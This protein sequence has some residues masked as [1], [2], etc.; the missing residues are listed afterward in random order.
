MGATAV[1]QL[2]LSDRAV[3][4]QVAAGAGTAVVITLS[5]VAGA[6]ALASAVGVFFGYY[7]CAASPPCHWLRRCV[8]SGASPRR[9]SLALVD[10]EAL[11]TGHDVV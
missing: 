4:G 5:P 1:E 3:R 8:T 2:F 11:E 7:R 6:F 9:L 10:D